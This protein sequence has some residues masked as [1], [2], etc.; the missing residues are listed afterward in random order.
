MSKG[1]AYDMIFEGHRMK[2]IGMDACIQEQEGGI[3][4]GFHYHILQCEPMIVPTVDSKYDV[5]WVISL[6]L[7]ISIRRS[8]MN[9][10]TGTFGNWFRNAICR[11]A[12]ITITDMDQLRALAAED[13][14]YI[15]KSYLSV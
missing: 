8:R 11:A 1:S 6:G 2:E 4:D 7:R 10:R 3:R 13:H 12:S 9:N 14:H 15:D 5:D